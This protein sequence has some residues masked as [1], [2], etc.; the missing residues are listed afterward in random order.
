MTYAHSL[1]AAGNRHDLREHLDTVASLARAY[2]EPFGGG[3]FARIA[4]LLHDVGKASPAFQQ[5][6][7]ACEREPDRRHKTVDH[8]GAGTLAA[9]EAFELLAFLIDG[10][11][12]GLPDSSA[13]RTT[14]KELLRREETQEALSLASAEGLLPAIDALPPALLPSYF[15]PASRGG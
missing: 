4:G 13:L 11:H 10:H 9:I 5:Y 8:K 6:L 2:A 7:A 12:G 15:A 14:L 1:N 3:D